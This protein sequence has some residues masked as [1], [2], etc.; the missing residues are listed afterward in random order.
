MTGYVICAAC[1]ARIKADRER[2]LRCEEP[3]RAAA[4]RVEPLR[5]SALTLAQKRTAV[6]AAGALIVVT[7]VLVWAMRPAPLDEV[8]RPVPVPAAAG[9]PGAPTQQP[10][11]VQATGDYEPFAARARDASRAGTAAMTS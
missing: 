4:P 11:V 8:A 1:G 3:L 10:A 7:A 5:W 9:V 6:A 2:C